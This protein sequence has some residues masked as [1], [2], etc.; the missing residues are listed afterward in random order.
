MAT[1]T[2]KSSKSVRQ[3]IQLKQV[4]K[5]WKAISIVNGKTN[6]TPSGFL[7]VY[8]GWDRIRFL[9]PTRFL[10]Y[11]IFLALLDKSGEEFGF[12]ISGGLV[13]PCDVEF[14]KEVLNLLQKD[15]KRNG[16][17]ELDQFLKK[18]PEVSTHF[19]SST[20]NCCIK[21]DGNAYGHFV[22]LGEPLM[23]KA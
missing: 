16:G 13:L 1:C 3:A 21:E 5:L 17:L 12:K 14:F 15:E 19:D 7:P 23:E 9:I 20:C 6:P 4:M 11:P 18:I 10:K 2:S 8:V 22:G